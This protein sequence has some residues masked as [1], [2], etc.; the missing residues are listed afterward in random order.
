MT[1][2]ICNS[3]Y[4]YPIKNTHQVMKSKRSALNRIPSRGHYN[5]ETIHT[6]L[7]NNF[8]CHVAFVIEG[9][10]YCIPTAY[11]RDGEDIYLHG[12]AKSQMLKVLANGEEACITIMQVDAIVLARSLFH[13][14]MNYHSVVLFGNGEE[15]TDPEEKMHG[16]RIVSESMWSG[17]WEEARH[18]TD[19]EMRATKVIRFPISEGSAKIRTG[20]AKDEKEDYDLKI[21]AGI[22]PVITS[23]GQPV[24]DE[25][26]RPDIDIPN[27]VKR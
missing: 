2:A 10:P 18:P 24:A 7:D 4:F 20:G 17:R 12:S 26:L 27:S 19:N 22:I 15:I 3:V 14:S 9:K 5:T 11:G 21:W 16:L 6:I 1:E 25:L 8:M 13:S 23:Y